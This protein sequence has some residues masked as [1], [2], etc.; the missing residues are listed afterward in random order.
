MGRAR[1]RVRWR[2]QPEQEETSPTHGD[3]DGDTECHAECHA[4]CDAAGNPQQREYVAVLTRLEELQWRA[5]VALPGEDIA[6][7]G[8]LPTLITD[9]LRGEISARAPDVPASYVI[10]CVDSNQNTLVTYVVGEVKVGRH[11]ADG[12]LQD[13]AGAASSSSPVTDTPA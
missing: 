7:T 6:V 9:Q 13:L 8:R 1:G 12:N 4:E 11:R 3:T 5:T 2:R 10:R